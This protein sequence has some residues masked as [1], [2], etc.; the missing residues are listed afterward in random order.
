MDVKTRH[1]SHLKCRVT[2]HLLSPSHGE[3]NAPILMTSS[4]STNVTPTGVLHKITRQTLDF[5]FGLAMIDIFEKWSLQSLI[6]LG[7]FVKGFFRL[8]NTPL[9]K[10]MALLVLIC[11]GLLEI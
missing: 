10:D 3:V 6:R 9:N 2:P 11:F 1:G 7:L 4:S 8:V 5:G